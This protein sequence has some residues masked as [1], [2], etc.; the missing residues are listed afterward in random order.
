[1]ETTNRNGQLTDEDMRRFIVNGYH[2]V[3]T[4][5]APEIH[6]KVLARLK[7]HISGKANPGDNILPMVP[8][9]TQ[10]LS[11]PALDGALAGIFG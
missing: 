11:S 5:I 9:L 8:E 3:D 10:V 7:A 4:D 1:M 6:S 2:R